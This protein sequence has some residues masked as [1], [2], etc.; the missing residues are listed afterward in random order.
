MHCVDLICTSIVEKVH[1]FLKHYPQEKS[2]GFEVK[3]RDIYTN[4]GTKIYEIDSAGH[5]DY[6]DFKDSDDII[7]N[8]LL[9]YRGKFT[10]LEQEVVVKY[11]FKLQNIHRSPAI[12]AIPI[13]SFYN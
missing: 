5:A 6:Y 8:F 2:I 9:N 4:G 10:P 7:D 1:N 3:P 12:F 11:D 13:I